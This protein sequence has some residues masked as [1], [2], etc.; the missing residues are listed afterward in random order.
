[1]RAPR[2]PLAEPDGPNLVTLTQV[3]TR[4]EAEVLVSML[5]AYGIAAHAP[6]YNGRTRLIPVNVARIDLDGAQALR[7]PPAQG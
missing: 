3:G 1:M 7:A 2:I 6:V 4:G 5:R